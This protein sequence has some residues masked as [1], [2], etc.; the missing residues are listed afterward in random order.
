MKIN[1]ISKKEKGRREC[2]IYANRAIER[3]CMGRN[4]PPTENLLSWS[5][6]KPTQIKT[7]KTKKKGEGLDI[8]K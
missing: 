5:Q 3:A 6:T 7:I 1:T 8:C 2:W 4:M